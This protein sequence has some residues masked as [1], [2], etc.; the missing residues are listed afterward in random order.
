[1]QNYLHF[2]LIFLIFLG[3]AIWFIATLVVFCFGLKIAMMTYGF[4]DERPHLWQHFVGPGAVLASIL[5]GGGFVMAVSAL[6]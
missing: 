1:M 6:H 5:S 3:F 4:S 2:V